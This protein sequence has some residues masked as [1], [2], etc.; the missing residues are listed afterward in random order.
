MGLLFD[1]VIAEMM[2][3]K[4]YGSDVVAPAFGLVVSVCN[5]LEMMV[6]KC[7]NELF[8]TVTKRNKP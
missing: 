8:I 5:L 3:G 6:I 7:M 1:Q 4:V 2:Q